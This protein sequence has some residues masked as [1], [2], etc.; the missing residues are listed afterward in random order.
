MAPHVDAEP[1]TRFE[2]WADNGDTRVKW[3]LGRSLAAMFL[4]IYTCAFGASA[5]AGTTGGIYGTLTDEDTKAPLAGAKITAKSPSQVATLTT[6]SGGH[7]SFPSLAPDTYTINSE[8]QGYG[9]STVT[10]V[11]VVA[12][13]QQ[14]IDI[15]QPKAAQ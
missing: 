7:F 15:T 10:D 2:T 12:D 3:K 5:S 4:G 1:R 8:K 14:T 11:E 9:E 13:Q 6:D